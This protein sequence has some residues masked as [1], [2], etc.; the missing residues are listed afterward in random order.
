[1]NGAQERFLRQQAVLH[2]TALKRSSLYHLIRV[3]AFPGPI[4]IGKRAVA[5][6]E[7]AINAWISERIAN[8]KSLPPSGAY[9]SGTGQALTRKA[10]K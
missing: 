8:A 2:L 10:A 5:W 7:S 4:R 3:G 9:T 1:M 6:P